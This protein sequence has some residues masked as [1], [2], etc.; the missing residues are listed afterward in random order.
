MKKAVI[1]IVLK[2]KYKGQFRFI[3]K[4]KNGEIIATSELYT[5]KQSC[6]KT[7]KNHFSEFKIEDGTK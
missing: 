2:G 4:S 7:L 1:K 3:L 5:Q 6:I